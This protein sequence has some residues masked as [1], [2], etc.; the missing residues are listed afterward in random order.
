MNPIHRLKFF[1]G[2]I[3]KKHPL[4]F[5]LA[6]LALRK[7]GRSLPHDKSFFGFKYLATEPDGLF[8]D[9][10]ANNG[11]SALSFHQIQPNF[12]IFSIEINHYHQRYLDNIRRK[13]QR[14]DYRIIGLSDEPG[15]ATLYTPIYWGTAISLL[16]SLDIDWLKAEVNRT[17]LAKYIPK[18]RYEAAAVQVVL[19][20]DLCNELDLVPSI[21]KIDAEGSDIQILRGMEQTVRHYRPH[22]MVEYSPLQRDAL[23]TFC[24]AVQYEVFLFNDTLS[25][26]EEFSDQKALDQHQRGDFAVNPFCIPQEKVGL[27]PRHSNHD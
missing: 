19:L 3:L 20:D 27:L 9:I 13:I 24:Q 14:F 16:S 10:G 17:F 1:A 11:L 21:I 26:F 12:K 15:E 6:W 2:R 23:I 4:L 7:L 22:I 5:P 18:I 8:L 25:Y